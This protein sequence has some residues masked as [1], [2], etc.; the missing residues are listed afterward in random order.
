VED[1]CGCLSFDLTA[2]AEADFDPGDN[3]RLFLIVTEASARDR[4]ALIG[5]CFRPASFTAA[6]KP[7]PAVGG[8][9]GF[10]QKPTPAQKLGCVKMPQ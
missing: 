10:A 6:V 2:L 9:A 7:T 8:A 4:I 3:R 5:Q 1:K